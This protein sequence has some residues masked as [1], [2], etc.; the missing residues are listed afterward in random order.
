M[1]A[2]DI[3]IALYKAYATCDQKVIRALLDDNA[4]WVAPAGN[5]TQ[6]GLGLAG[7]YDAGPPRGI[8]D[9]G[10]E[11]IARFMSDDFPRFFANARNE[12]RTLI[13]EGDTAVIEHR[14]SA[15]LPT[16]EPYVND[17]CFIVQTRD[18]KVLHIREYMDTRGGW[19]QVF[20]SGGGR[21]LC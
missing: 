12:I 14:L 20:G 6:V 19:Q 21:K 13:G 18:E 16:G 4:V 10:A 5:A 9:L 3:V 1:A 2:K 8:N 7:G 15:T 17:Y 11:E